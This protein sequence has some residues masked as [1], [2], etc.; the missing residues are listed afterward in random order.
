MNAKTGY[1]AVAAA[2]L[3]GV[4]SVGGLA[5]AHEQPASTTKLS[6]QEQVPLPSATASAAPPPTSAQLDPAARRQLRDDF[7]NQLAQ[8]LN[9]SRSTLNSA[10]TTTIGQEIDKAVAANQLTAQQAARLKKQIGKD[11]FPIGLHLGSSANHQTPAAPG[12]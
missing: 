6:A 7:L 9:I 8:N 1:V 12:Q 11:R 5:F 2:V 3:I 10:L 4:A